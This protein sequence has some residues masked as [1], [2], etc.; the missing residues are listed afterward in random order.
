MSDRNYHTQRWRRLATACLKRDPWC[1]T[2]GCG[3]PSR[4]ADHVVPRELGGPDALSNL[5]GLCERCHNRRSRLGN[6]EVV[7]IGCD[8]S[9]QP[10]DPRHWWNR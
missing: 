4:H 10:R 1:T 3:M 5:R 6:T 9:G 2:P 7:A 8:A